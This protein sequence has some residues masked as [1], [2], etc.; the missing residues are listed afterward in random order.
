MQQRKIKGWLPPSKLQ[1]HAWHTRTTTT[2]TALERE[3]DIAPKILGDRDVVKTMGGEKNY[4]RFATTKGENPIKS[5]PH[6]NEA[7]VMHTS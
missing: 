6:V 2:K 7:G 4:K 1:N 5:T 3:T